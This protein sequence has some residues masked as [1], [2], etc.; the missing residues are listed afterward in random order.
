MRHGPKEEPPGPEAGSSCSEGLSGGPPTRGCWAVAS[1]WAW[2]R[3]SS[4]QGREESP[5]FCLSPPWEAAKHQ[6][7]TW[8]SSRLA[9]PRAELGLGELG[10]PWQEETGAVA[11]EALIPSTA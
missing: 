6:W 9:A 7:D 11:M 1:S 8:L 4:C 5:A 3:F 10:G 2:D